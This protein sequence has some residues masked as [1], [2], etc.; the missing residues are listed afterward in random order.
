[1]EGQYTW[2]ESIKVELEWKSNSHGRGRGILEL[3]RHLDQIPYLY[4]NNDEDDMT[5]M[6]KI[7]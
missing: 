4:D 6:K 7:R 5:P 2:N 3:V 1:M